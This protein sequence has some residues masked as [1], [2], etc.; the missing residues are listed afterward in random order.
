MRGLT[1]CF[2]THGVCTGLEGAGFASFLPW[3]EPLPSLRAWC[4]FPCR[5]GATFQGPGCIHGT[6]KAPLGNQGRVFWPWVG[7]LGSQDT[8]GSVPALLCSQD[9]MT[10]WLQRDL[11]WQRPEVTVI[12][13]RAQRYTESE[14]GAQL[15]GE[16]GMGS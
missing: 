8:R 5:V 12:L 14:H 10:P 4:P 16:T 6:G 2:H 7:V 11:S 1:L 15:R 3:V 9:V 13:L